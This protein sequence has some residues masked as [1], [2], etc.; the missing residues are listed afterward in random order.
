MIYEIASDLDS[1]KSL[2]FDK[3]LNVLLADKSPGASDLQSRNGA[4]KS[5]MVELIHFLLGGNATTR[6]IFRTALKEWTFHLTLD[7]GETK[8]RVSR[9]GA[10]PQLVSVSPRQALGDGF[11]DDNGLSNDGWKDILGETWF[12]LPRRAQA[13]KFR[14]TFRSLFSFVARR[15][16]SGGFHQPMQHSTM[17]QQW[18]RQ[19]AICYLID[20]DST[21]PGRFKELRDRETG[22]SQLRKAVSA[23]VVG[24]FFRS[25]GEL[26]TPLAIAED[27]SQRLRDRLGR[28]E[29]LPQYRELEV[30]ASEI[31]Q[32]IG[33][34]NLD[35]VVDEELI[36]ELST[37]LAAEVPPEIPDLAD[38]YEEAGVVLPEVTKRRFE[39]VELFHKTVIEN[40]RVH[41]RSEIEAAKTRIEAR[42]LDKRNMDERRQQ[43][44]RLL[45]GRGALDHYTS[46]RE[47]LGRAEAECQMLRQQ[48]E[49][50]ELFETTKAQLAMER[51]ALVQAM[52]NDMHERDQVIRDVILKFETL[53]RSL[54]ERA[55]SLRIS[56]SKGGPKF[57]ASIEGER[58]KGI[59]NMQI[60]CFDLTL[61]EIGM[62]QCRWPGF[63]IHDSHLFDGVDERQVAKALQ[64]GASRA[65]QYGFQYIVTMNSDSLPTTGYE[66][67]FRVEDYVLE[68]KLTD[69]TE[70]GGLFG[71]RF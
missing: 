49:T 29:V 28:F 64:I 66:D 62:T 53:S 39:D 70:T 11:L 42:D 59:T 32:K 71:L 36:Q 27:R 57:E 47:E 22:A 5:S 7:V 34:L 19:A 8:A 65:E 41:L 17:Q 63:L 61:A 69:A 16:E 37:A 35:N 10:S 51:A 23:G 24:E 54:Y 45:R 14:P 56:S 50:A 4:G 44:M 25:S 2:T 1:F 26:R 30:E 60:F 18:D 68:T 58:S 21:I 52:Q 46:L 31:T 33:K 12:R 6:S 55:G 40:R 67:G 48:L 3:G 15:Q 13:M 43:V 9:T 20:L 38:L